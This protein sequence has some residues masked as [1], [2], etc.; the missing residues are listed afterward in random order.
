MTAP[1]RR[2]QLVIGKVAGR[3]HT[4]QSARW[5]IPARTTGST[6]PRPFSRLLG[7]YQLADALRAEGLVVHTLWSVYGTAEQRLEDHDWVAD[8]GLHGWIVLSADKRVG[9]R[10]SVVAIEL[11]IRR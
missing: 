6:E 11:R 5:Q 8:A 2:V 10:R 9:A 7:R 4:G 1:A 3:A